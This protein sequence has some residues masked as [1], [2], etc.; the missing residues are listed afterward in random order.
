LVF[1]DNKDFHNGLGMD[2]HIRTTQEPFGYVDIPEF[3]YSYI[4]SAAIRIGDDVLEFT[5]DDFF[6]NGVKGSD[7]DLP[8]TIGDGFT[9]HYP[10]YT[11]ESKAKHYLIDLNGG[12]YILFYKYLHFM[13]LVIKGSHKDFG[14]S[15]GLMGDFSTSDMFAR[16]GKTILHDTNQFGSEWQVHENEQKL[17]R[18]LREPQHPHAACKVP[19]NTI[20]TKARRH[21]RSDEVF[22][23]AAEEA[24]AHKSMHGFESCVFDVL[25]TKDL[26][27]ARAWGL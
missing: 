11:E 8:T 14:T 20:V 21:L 19:D 16:D 3:Y 12:D 22:M 10:T 25:A 18:T 6:I 9:L 4:E 15:V 1:L 23:K 17:F 7:S 24:C 2:I 26:G 13:S 5:G 27:M